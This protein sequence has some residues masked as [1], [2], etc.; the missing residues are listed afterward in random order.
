MVQYRRYIIQSARMHKGSSTKTSSIQVFK[1]DEHADVL[2]KQFRY[3]V[4]DDDSL[5]RAIDR[6]RRYIE[7]VSDP[8]WMAEPP[9][10][11]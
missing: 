4:S 7:S 1:R 11:G 10:A 9:S 3:T 5:R 6:A 8:G 2:V